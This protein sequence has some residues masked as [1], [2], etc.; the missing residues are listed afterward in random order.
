MTTRQATYCNTTTDLWE[1]DPDVNIH[2]QKHSI[3]NW[4]QSTGNL[5][6]ADNVGYISVLFADGKDLGDPEESV[7]DVDADGE[8]YY[9]SDTDRVT[10]YLDND[11][12]DTLMEGGEDWDTIK[13]RAVQRASEVVKSYINRAI[14]PRKGVGQQTADSRNYDWVI[15]YSTAVI[16][17]SL[18]MRSRSEAAILRREAINPAFPSEIGEPPGWLDQVKNGS[19]KLWNEI[20]I[21]ETEGDV[22]VIQEDSSST[23]GILDTRVGSGGIDTDWDLIKI[24]IGTGGT[25]TEGTTN[26]TVT[27]SS[28][29]SSGTMI[30]KTVVRDDDYIELD[31][32]HVGQ[33]L[34]VRF[35]PGVYTADDEYEIEVSN[36][37]EEHG[38]IS[39]V[40]LVRA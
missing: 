24:I 34:Y 39:S 18:L 31:Y 2:D 9:D 15:T 38:K 20:G 4:T 27:F 37:P 26:T 19:I 35:A 7:D 17:V 13:T 11:I 23:G 36:L 3:E 10:C 25:V 14:I 8:W 21:A 40:R 33:N 28:Y 30:K 29:I 16:A 5:Y 22:R 12:L 32:Q 1:V 6:Y